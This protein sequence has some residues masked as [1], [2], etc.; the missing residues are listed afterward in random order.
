MMRGRPLRRS[1]AGTDEGWESSGLNAS[2]RVDEVAG[3]LRRLELD[4]LAA[5]RELARPLGG[6]LV[7]DE[8]PVTIDAVM[9]G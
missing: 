7:F 2:I 1:P 3:L 5:H 4:R 8:N 6:S 9:T